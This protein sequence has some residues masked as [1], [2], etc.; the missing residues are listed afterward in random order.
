VPTGKHDLFGKPGTCFLM[1]VSRLFVM[2]GC[3]PGQLFR[4][5]RNGIISISRGKSEGRPEGAR[6][7]TAGDEP[8]EFTSRGEG[9]RVPPFFEKLPETGFLR[10][11][12]TVHLTRPPCFV[13]VPKAE[14]AHRLL[15]CR[16]SSS[17]TREISFSLPVG[18]LN[19]G[20]NPHQKKPDTPMLSFTFPPRGEYE[21]GRVMENFGLVNRINTSFLP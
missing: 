21:G 15:Q 14:T 19:S 4:W 8:R 7:P 10:K 6:R 16:V 20:R 11:K 17:L 5:N 1:L 3:H 13:I 18:S 2:A 12:G 9:G